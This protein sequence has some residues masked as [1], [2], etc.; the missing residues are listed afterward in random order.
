M[1]TVTLGCCAMCK[2][3]VWFHFMELVSLSYWSIPIGS[4]K[5]IFF[6][7]LILC[8]NVVRNNT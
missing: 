1:R 5:K 6:V 4:K 2:M 8:I 7:L 3:N